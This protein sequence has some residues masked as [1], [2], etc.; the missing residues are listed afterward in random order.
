M[1]FV[2]TT[3]AYLLNT[4]PTLGPVTIFDDGA[5]DVLTA[6]GALDWFFIRKK[7]DVI[8]NRKPGDKVTQV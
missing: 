8:N 1:W 4:D 7:I 5:A 2:R 3:G 6:G